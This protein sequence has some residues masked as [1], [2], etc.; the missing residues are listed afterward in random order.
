[1]CGMYYNVDMVVRVLVQE[2]VAG[3][4]LAFLTLLS[5]LTKPPGIYVSNIVVWYY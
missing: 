2:A 4:Y 5:Q 3:S 1:M